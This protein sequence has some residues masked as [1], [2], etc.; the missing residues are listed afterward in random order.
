[1]VQNR[2]GDQ[3][4]VIFNAVGNWP[5]DTV[6][7]ADQDAV[8]IEVWEPYRKF[9]GPAPAGVQGRNAGRRQAGDHRGVYPPGA[10]SHNVRLAN[11]VIFASGG[12]HLELGE[13]GAM[14][15]DPY[16]PKFGMMDESMQAM[17]QSYYDF[18]VRYEEMLALDTTNAPD[19][20]K[21]LTIEGD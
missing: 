19:R 7:P 10:N 1:M 3:G 13:P 2:R 4:A 17:M 9:Y 21:A 18:L 15:A 11:A 20:A 12:N 5:V 14:L 16:F 6:A 8:Y